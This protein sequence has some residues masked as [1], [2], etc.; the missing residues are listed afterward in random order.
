MAQV[1]FAAFQALASIT[2]A[3]ALQP[4]QRGELAFVVVAG[5]LASQVFER[6]GEYGAM[7][8]RR[9]GMRLAQLLWLP[10]VLLAEIVAAS[11]A[12]LAVYVQSRDPMLAAG[13]GVLAA[14]G[15]F[16]KWVIG[17]ILAEGRSWLVVMAR[18]LSPV[19]VL[20]GSLVLVSVEAP[21][22]GRF[23]TLLCVSQLGAIGAVLLVR[24]R[25]PQPWPAPQADEPNRAVDLRLLHAGNIGIYAL[26]RCDQFLLG[27]LGFHSQLGL[28]AVAV[29]IAEV[30]QYLPTVGTTLLIAGAPSERR[31]VWRLVGWT[32]AAVLVLL[33]SFGRE[34]I[35]ALYGTDYR[36]A[37]RY[38]LPLLGAYMVFSV[39]RLI[40]GEMVAQQRYRPFAIGSLTS[41]IIG[42]PLIALLVRSSNA[43]GAAWGSLI[44]YSI[45][46]VAL[47]IAAA[48]RVPQL[49]RR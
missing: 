42:I 28:Y 3:R 6:G 34:I 15:L 38:L 36:P 32:T 35:T 13:S 8:L 22:L 40:W 45:L 29:N 47:G 16:S 14:A 44:G 30:S 24:A 18:V 48:D 41:A 4:A 49:R 27:A 20:A 1:G 9:G 23:V 2:I 39:A 7:Q 43:L 12:A 10:G 37:S 11:T 17:G 21:S 19:V 46:V 26:Y 33:A 25:R 5:V 31:R